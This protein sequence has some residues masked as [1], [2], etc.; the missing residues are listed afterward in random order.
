MHPTPPRDDPAPAPLLGS[1]PGGIPDPKNEQFCGDFGEEGEMESGWGY[2]LVLPLLPGAGLLRNVGLK[3]AARTVCC[4][5][6]GLYCH[7]WLLLHASAFQSPWS[8]LLCMLLTR[9]LLA[10]PYIHVNIFQVQTPSP[11][12]SQGCRSPLP[13]P[14]SPLVSAIGEQPGLQAPS[15]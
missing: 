11:E 8:A 3:V 7:Y 9:S 13:A 1:C 12:M 5:S 2:D 4:M 10:H 6:L 14:A 15:C